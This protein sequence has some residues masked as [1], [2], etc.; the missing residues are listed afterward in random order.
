MNTNLMTRIG[1][2]LKVK[3]TDLEVDAKNLNILKLKQN[4]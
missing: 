2:S 1:M 3:K 4:P